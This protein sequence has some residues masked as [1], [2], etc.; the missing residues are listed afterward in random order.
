MTQTR[1]IKRLACLLALSALLCMSLAGPVAADGEITLQFGETTIEAVGV[2]PGAEIVFY[3]LN[4]TLMHGVAV[5]SDETYRRLDEDAD[6]TVLLDLGKEVPQR[7]L[8][9][10]F[11]DE[12]DGKI[13]IHPQRM[14]ALAGS[15]P[16]PGGL[17]AQDLVVVID[18][19][20]MKDA[21]V[22]PRN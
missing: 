22:P 8:W 18:P 9:I 5:V 6:G 19:R 21:V 14:R 13:T 3:G 15:P 20:R 17:A 12:P 11:D 2:S 16:S 10:A 1:R 4:R 7:S